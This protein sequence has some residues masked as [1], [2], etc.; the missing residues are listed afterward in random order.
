[1]HARWLIGIAL[2]STTSVMVV[3]AP[4]D[5]RRYTIP[6]SG[7][8]V[9]VPITIFEDDAG[10][11][12]GTHG[13]QLRTRDRRADLPIKSVPNPDNDSPAGFLEKMNPPAGIQYKRVTSRFFAVSSIRNGRT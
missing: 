9:D 5:W 3:A 12:E 4:L 10:A 11:V 13:R 8:S 7:L 6:E 1:M 2:L